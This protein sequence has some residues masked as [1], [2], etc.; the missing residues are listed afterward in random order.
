MIRGAAPRNQRDCERRTQSSA[1]EHR[2]ALGS[3][4]RARTK[5]DGLVNSLLPRQKKF[6]VLKELANGF[7]SPVDRAVS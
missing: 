2:M 4:I 6:G 5:P 7:P 1:R 3:L